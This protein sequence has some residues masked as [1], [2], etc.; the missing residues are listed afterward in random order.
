[1]SNHTNLTE[2]ARADLNAAVL[3]NDLDPAIWLRVVERMERRLALA[4]EV[5]AR[6]PRAS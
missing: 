6:T 5:D 3:R 2:S 4:I 1:M